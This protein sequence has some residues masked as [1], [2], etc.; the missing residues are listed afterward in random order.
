[1][2]HNATIAE[3]AGDNPFVVNNSPFLTMSTVF[4]NFRASYHFSDKTPAVSDRCVCRQQ[5]SDL[6]WLT[7]IARRTGIEDINYHLISSES[8][9]M[10]I[11]VTISASAIMSV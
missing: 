2:A 8:E 9:G 4:G 1:M 6:N 11:S 7:G 5:N 10:V 3:V